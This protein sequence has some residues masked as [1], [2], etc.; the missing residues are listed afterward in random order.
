MRVP[1]AVEDDGQCLVRGDPEPVVN[2]PRPAVFDRLTNCVPPLV[3]LRGWPVGDDDDQVC[4]AVSSEH[5][6]DLPKE[7]GRPVEENDDRGRLVDQLSHA[8][9][10]VAA[11]VLASRSD[12]RQ[13]LAW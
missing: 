3:E 4:V 13:R 11:D 9:L 1:V 2:V 6:L 5:L 10:P 8:R 12:W 7:P